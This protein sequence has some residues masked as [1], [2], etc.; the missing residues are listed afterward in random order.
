MYHTIRTPTLEIAYLECGPVDGT[1]AIL[2]HGWPSDV[3]DWDQVAAD[4]AAGGFRVFVPGYAAS[5]QPVFLSHQHHDRGS[6]RHWARIC[7]LLWMH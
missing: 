4:L 3:H 7:V 5:V 6:K 2:L 1:P